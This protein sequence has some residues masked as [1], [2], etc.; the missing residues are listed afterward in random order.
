M[1]MIFICKIKP[2]LLLIY[3]ILKERR[4]ILGMKCKRFSFFFLFLL[5]S[6]LYYGPL[7]SYMWSLNFFY[8]HT[9]TQTSTMNIMLSKLRLRTLTQ[10]I[11][12]QVRLIS[13]AFLHINWRSN[14]RL[15]ST[16][17][18]MMI[19]LEKQHWLKIDIGIEASTW[20]CVFISLLIK[21]K[22]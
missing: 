4:G 21:T 6:Y 10:F 9:H 14:L 2:I 5:Y 8:A 22:I 17:P 11:A 1:C 18:I 20:I 15:F 3:S 7:K 19:V 16:S 12:I 13:P